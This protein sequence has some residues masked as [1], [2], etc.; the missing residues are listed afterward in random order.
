MREAVFKTSVCPIIR[1]SSRI[2]PLISRNGMGFE[3]LP[4]QT[5]DI[6]PV[7]NYLFCDL[8][9]FYATLGVTTVTQLPKHPVDERP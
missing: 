5:S 8:F 6:R 4:P 3:A 7:T 9:I 1:H 2:M